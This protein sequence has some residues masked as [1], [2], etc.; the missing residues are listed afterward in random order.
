MS[1]IICMNLPAFG[2]VNPHLAVVKALTQSGA[3]V[4]FYTHPRFKTR[5]N[6]SGAEFLPYPVPT[7]V[8]MFQQRNIFRM[9]RCLS[10]FGRKVIPALRAEVAGQQADLIMY[11]V[12]CVWG[13]VVAKELGLPSVASCP[14]LVPDGAAWSYWHRMLPRYLSALWEGKRD[15]YAFK[16]NAR[17]FERQYG[18]E[19]YS[20]RSAFH[21]PADLNLVYTSKLFQPSFERVPENYAFVGPVVDMDRDEEE[22]LPDEINTDQPIV[23]IS[24]GTVASTDRIPIYQALFKAFHDLPV[25]LVVSTGGLTDFSSL[26]T[27]PANFLLKDHISQLAV[28]RVAS[29]FVTHGGA[30]SVHEGL[31]FNLPLLVIPQTFEQTLN[32]LTVHETGTGLYL[33]SRLPSAE[34][35]RKALQQLL[36]SKTFQKR[37][38]EMK[39]SFLSAGGAEEAARLVHEVIEKGATSKK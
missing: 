36:E 7:Q 29:A 5:I 1:R 18:L 27:I 23:Y 20:I 9:A 37:I 6:S 13:K 31:L 3:E 33:G 12:G 8:N 38:H 10:D 2:H 26:G 21:N 24:L 32:A 16:K 34:A 25:Q 19:G 17:H 28:L 39:E 30:N 11:D 15:L 4:V 35:M 22:S 14:I